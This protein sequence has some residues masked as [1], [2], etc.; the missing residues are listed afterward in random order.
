MFYLMALQPTLNMGAVMTLPVGPF[1]KA[2]I[3]MHNLAIIAM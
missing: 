2:L 1:G 3:E